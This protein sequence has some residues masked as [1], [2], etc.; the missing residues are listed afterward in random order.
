MTMRNVMTK[1]PDAGIFLFKIKWSRRW[2]SNPQPADYKSAALPIELR[3]HMNYQWSGRQDSNL[4][5][6]G[7]EPSALP[8][9]ATPRFFQNVYYHSKLN[10][11]CQV[12]YS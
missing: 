3:R 10:L 11:A 9:C 6:L 5:P 7:P 4:R 12:N 1:S 8:N 2:D